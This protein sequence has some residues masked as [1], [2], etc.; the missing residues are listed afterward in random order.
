[1]PRFTLE[2]DTDNDAFALSLADAAQ[3]LAH[4]LRETARRVEA[5]LIEGPIRDTNGNRIGRF[6]T[7]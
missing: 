4:V 3:S 7:Q 1:M 5:G 2:I 6:G